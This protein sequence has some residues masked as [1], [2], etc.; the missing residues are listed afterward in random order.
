[1]LVTITGRIASSA[2][3]PEGFE[4]NINQHSVVIRTRNKSMSEYLAVFL[5]STIGQ[6]LAIKRT[7]G[8]TRPAL[9]YKALIKIPV[10][11]GV[12]I[13][14]IMRKAYLAKKEKEEQAKKLLDGIDDYLLSELGID[15]LEKEED[16]LKS[17]IF[18]RRFSEVSGG[19]LDAF[20]NSLSQRGRSGTYKFYKL[21]EIANLRKGDPIT[22]DGV[23]KGNIPV[24]AGGQT[25]PYTHNVANCKGDVITVSASGYA[26]YVWYHSRPIFAS[27]CTIISSDNTNNLNNKFLF[28]CLKSEQQNI[29][30]LQQG[31]NQPHVYPSDLGN[32]KIPLPPLEKQTEIANHI[33]E[34]RDQAKRLREQARADLE[35]AKQ[36][37]ETMILEG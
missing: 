8:G 1:M 5:N 3:A 19:R 25:S 17:R 35:Q 33:A 37:V 13:V 34:I 26:G 6:K 31:S 10:V 14:E 18:T 12:P 20:F 22:R 32:I 15:L 11:E 29:Y 9:D 36:E 21:K 16:T 28:E 24:I 27:D 7:T 4:G 30:N 2:V 23:V